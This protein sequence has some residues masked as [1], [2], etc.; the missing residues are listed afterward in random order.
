MPE[1]EFEALKEKLES[2]ENVIVNNI[3]TA[4]GTERKREVL[5]NA[6]RTKGYRESLEKL[7][8]LE[9]LKQL[10]IGGN[11]DGTEQNI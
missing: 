1:L 2:I 6:V 4:T 5:R 7:K 10:N 8:K 9:E 11:K 3:I